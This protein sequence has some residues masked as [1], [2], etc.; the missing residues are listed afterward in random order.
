M[1]VENA[2]F[3]LADRFGN[4]FTTSRNVLN[5]HGQDESYFPPTAPDGVV[6][7]ESTRQVT[8]IVAICAEENCP[9]V[10]WGVGTSLEGHA[11]AIRG[12]ITVDMSKMNRVIEINSDDLNVIVQPGI[13]R[14]ELEQELRTTG[15]FFPIDPGANATIGGMAATRAS[16]TTAVRY[17]TLKDN[18]LALEV[19]LASGKVVRTGSRARK[20]SAGYDLTA[21][22]VGSEGTLGIITELTLKLHGQPESI[23]AAVCHFDEI[24]PCV[25]AVIAIIQ[26]GIPVARLELV[27]SAMIRGLN[28]WNPDFN[29]PVMPHLFMEFHGSS[30]STG[31]HASD[32][33]NIVSEFGGSNFNWATRAED[34]AALWRARHNAYYAAKALRPNCRVLTTDACVPISRLAEAIEETTREIEGSPL[35][36][37]IVGHA[38]DGNFHVTL[39]VDENN[40]AELLEAKQIAGNINRRA[41]QLG[42][43]ITGEHG[44]GAGKLDYMSAEHGDAWGIMADIKRSLDPGNI[45]NPGKMVLFN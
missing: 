13:T 7:P 44:I 29:M 36:G 28:L 42:G 34:R 31:Q 33:G 10:P 2:V 4:G 26:L 3:R 11:L 9:V 35:A 12:G 18:V 8:E 23:V 27:D 24:A 21:L 37:P 45:M 15:L 43:T 19:V 38:G 17:G 14:K 20:T 5:E 1:S 25:E 6:Y 32:A 39:L 16:G 22:F 30:V 41:L 40:T